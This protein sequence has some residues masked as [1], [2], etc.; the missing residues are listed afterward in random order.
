[1]AVRLL[2]VLLALFFRLTWSQQL[3]GPPMGM[4]YNLTTSCMQAL[5]TNVTCPSA[6]ADLAI[7]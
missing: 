3:Q 5:N 6:L 4:P 2:F 1:M 7:E